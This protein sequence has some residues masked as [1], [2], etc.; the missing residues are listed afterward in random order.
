MVSAFN[1]WWFYFCVWRYELAVQHPR[2]HLNL[3]CSQ[4]PGGNMWLWRFHIGWRKLDH[5]GKWWQ[6]SGSPQDQHSNRTSRRTR[7]VLDCQ[8]KDFRVTFLVGFV[9]ERLW[10]LAGSSWDSLNNL[11]AEGKCRQCTMYQGQS[12]RVGCCQVCNPDCGIPRHC[13]PNHQLL[14]LLMGLSKGL[15]AVCID[16]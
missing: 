6:S 13:A 9:Q 11:K 15:S 10:F 3:L 4:R 8:E 1:Y 2:R 5:Y 16:L 7:H 12:P 14:H